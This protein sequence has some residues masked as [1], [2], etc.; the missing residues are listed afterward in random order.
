M[1]SRQAAGAERWGGPEGETGFWRAFVQRVYAGVGGGPL[2]ERLLEELVEHFRDQGHWRVYPEVEAV[3]AALRDAGYRLLV[4]SNWDSTLPGL[5][6]R[7]DLTRRFDAVVV[8]AIVG[9]S[10]PAREIFDAAL[11]TAGVGAAEALHVGD[12]PSEDYD[13]AR[14]AGLEALLL[15]R[16]GIA[17]DGFDTI[18]SLEA[19]VPLLVP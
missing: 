2:P 4:V 12:S 11:K 13:G 8:S 6:D 3:L 17:P 10:K 18:R 19:L 9:V 5:L 1:A 7:L 16:S 14:R 15:D